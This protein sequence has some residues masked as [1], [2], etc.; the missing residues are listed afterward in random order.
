MNCSH[1]DPGLSGLLQRASSCFARGETLKH[2]GTPNLPTNIIPTNI[3][4]LKLSGKCPMDM[5]IP[6]LWIKIMLESNPLKSTILVGRLGVV[7]QSLPEQICSPSRA[8][9]NWSMGFL[10]YTLPQTPGGFQRLSEMSV[11]TRQASC[12]YSEKAAFSRLLP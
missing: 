1:R 8:R 6:P 3:A 11:G 7:S 2:N 4:W 12:R 10:D 5:R 9:G